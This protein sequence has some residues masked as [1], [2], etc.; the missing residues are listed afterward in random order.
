M[1]NWGLMSLTAWA[2]SCA[3]EEWLIVLD[4]VSDSE[5]TGVRKKKA[6]L[7]IPPAAQIACVAII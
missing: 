5:K 1:T 4:M 3:D 7:T 2:I 6:D